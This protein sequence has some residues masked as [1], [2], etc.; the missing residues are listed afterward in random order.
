MAK[1]ERHLDYVTALE[2]T[3]VEVIRGTFDRP[4]RYCVA[5]D[6]WCRTYSEKK[7]NVAITINLLADG[8][9]DECD[10]AYL[11][12]ADSDHVP[13]VEKFLECFQGKALFV[14]APPNRLTQ[15]R[16][17]IQSVGRRSLQLTAGRLRQHLLPREFRVRKENVSRPALYG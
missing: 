12:S 4:R 7:T 1:R 16:E 9:R 10:I 5:N 13:L 17:L 6:L 15:A 3:N 14:I 11:M 8:Y 2:R